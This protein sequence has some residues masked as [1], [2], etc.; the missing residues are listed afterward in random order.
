MSSGS[1]VAI[2][3]CCSIWLSTSCAMSPSAEDLSETMVAETAAANQIQALEAELEN[4]TE[5]QLVRETI[6]AEGTQSMQM[7]TEAAEVEGTRAAETA[8]ANDRATQAAGPMVSF[9]EE[10]VEA[11]YLSS[12]D[13]WCIPRIVMAIGICIL[14]GRMER[15]NIAY[16]IAEQMR[17]IP[18]GTGSSV[19]GPVITLYVV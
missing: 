2:L 19:I 8:R 12:S 6:A 15:M 16:R 10:L 7:A 1:W 4:V 3:L 17:L 9:V 13:G 18:P 14:F 5:T 11:G